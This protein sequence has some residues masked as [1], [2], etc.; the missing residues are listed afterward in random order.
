MPQPSDASPPSAVML[1]QACPKCAQSMHLTIIEPH[2]R[3][4]NLE[5]RTFGCACGEMVTVVVARL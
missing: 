2:E 3:Y 4:K 5:N 1:T